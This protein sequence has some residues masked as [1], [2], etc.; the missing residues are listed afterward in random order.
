MRRTRMGR[1]A[2]GDLQAAANGEVGRVFSCLCGIFDSLSNAHAVRGRAGR[3]S[4]GLRVSEASS[5]RLNQARIKQQCISEG[6]AS[7][8]NGRAPVPRGGSDAR[9]T[10]R[11]YF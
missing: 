5:E 7:I 10:S 6:Q 8:S 9:A 2:V 1:T 4:L 11:S 3:I